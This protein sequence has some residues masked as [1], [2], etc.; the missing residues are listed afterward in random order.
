MYVS[1]STSPAARSSF[2]PHLE[3]LRGIAALGVLSTHVAFQTGLDP[4]SIAGAILSRFDFFVAVFFA[5]SAYLLWSPTRLHTGNLLAYYQ[6]RAIRILPAYIVCV[7][8]SL[9]LVPE[10][11]HAR[12]A[13]ILTTLTFTQLYIPQGLIGGLTHLWSLNVEVVFY[14]LLPIF[15]LVLARLRPL[16][17]MVCILILSLL[18]LAWAFLPWV[19]AGDGT[20]LPNRQIYPVAFSMWFAIGMIAAEL[21]QHYSHSSALRQ[22]TAILHRSRWVNWT[23]AI[24]IAWLAGQEFFGPLGLTHPSPLQFVLRLLAGTAF[25]TLILTSYL[26]PT[27]R[28]LLAHPIAQHLGKISYSLFLWHLPILSAVFAVTGISPFHGH[29]FTIWLLTAA[30]AIIVAWASF[31]WIEQPCRQALRGY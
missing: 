9:A 27:S 19:I 24:G 4:H 13:A 26:L 11:F 2:N 12:P 6:R 8:V 3:G 10:A 7:C 28:S 18:S 31:V 29:F 22:I 1:Y 5:L 14:L 21:V 17:R 30:A 23:L 25:A 15:A 20:A 16:L